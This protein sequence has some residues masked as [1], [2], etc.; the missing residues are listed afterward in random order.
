MTVAKKAMIL[1]A[2]A[3]L[4]AAAAAYFSGDVVD[5]AAVRE[6]VLV[7]AGALGGSQLFRRAGDDPGAL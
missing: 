4:V 1:R 7:L 3:V 6:G 5:G 2:V